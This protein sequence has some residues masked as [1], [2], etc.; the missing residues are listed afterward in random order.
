MNSVILD[1]VWKAVKIQQNISLTWYH[2]SEALVE[3]EG[4]MMDIMYYV[5]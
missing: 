1:S 2:I 4:Y 3:T 5:E